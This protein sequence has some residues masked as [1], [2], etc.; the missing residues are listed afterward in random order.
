MA[1]AVAQSLA[2]VMAGV[3]LGQLERPGSPAVFGNFLTTVNLKTGSPTFG[4]PE[5]ALGSFAAAQLA[6]RIGLPLRCSGAFT[7][8]KLPDAQAMQESVR[9][10]Y[11][12]LLC[13]ANF[14]LHAAGWLEAALTIGYE[15]L[16]LDADYLGAVHTLLGGLPVDSGALA[17]DAFKEV[18][19]G[20]HFFG[21]AYTLSRYETA[22]H[23][24]DSACK[25]D[26]LIGR[27]EAAALRAAFRTR[28]ASRRSQA[29]G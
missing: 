14:I 23:E 9:S 25:T 3:A 28:P 21:C 17:F 29:W 5:S 20:N 24:C 16:V 15:K 22:F 8:S 10:L 18:G 11:T 1:G 6:R 27:L 26:P 12:A 7:S 4:T 2:E 19:P 13:G